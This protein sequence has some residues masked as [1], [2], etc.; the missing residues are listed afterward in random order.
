MGNLSDLILQFIGNTG[1][2]MLDYRYSTMLIVGVVFIYLGIV[3]R[4][5]PLLL[6]P[7]GFGI[8]MG[9]IPVFKGLGL[10]V[11]EDNSVL[12]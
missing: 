1:Y 11:Y 12:H 2:Y 6:I 5:E 7:I 3:K 9:N 4:Y 8:L 10:A